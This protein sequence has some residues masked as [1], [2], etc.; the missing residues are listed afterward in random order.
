VLGA[1]VPSLSQKAAESLAKLGVT[2][3]TGTIVTD[4]TAEAVTVRRGEQSEVIP[5]RT[6]LWAAGV[7]ASPLGRLLATATGAEADRSGRVVVSADLSLPGRPEVFVIG[8]LASYSHQT[9]KPLPGLAPVAMQQGRYVADLIQRRLRGEP[10][11]PFHYHDRGV[12]ATIGAASAV[13]D[14][15]WIKLS[16]YPAWLAW[17][18]IHILY[19]VEFENRLLVIVQW[20]W[21]YFTRNRSAR[22][23]TGKKP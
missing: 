14:L 22:L 17:L 23:I 13:A 19:L 12:M 20:G 7:D 1:Y 5:T 2:V 16:G 15:G 21:N 18:F 4:V 10:P 9:G 8:D 3:R 11:R 6:V